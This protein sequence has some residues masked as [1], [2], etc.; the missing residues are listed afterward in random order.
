MSL[1]CPYALIRAAQSEAESLEQS[2]RYE[3]L[4]GRLSKKFPP[5]ERGEK[6]EGTGVGGR[7]FD[8]VEE[9]WDGEGRGAAAEGDGS[10]T[11]AWVA[12]EADLLASGLCYSGPH[13]A[14]IW[15]RT[16]VIAGERILDACS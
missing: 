16:W 6:A 15:V 14:E 4:E 8:E 3:N 10:A 5:R 9:G 11:H 1:N 12:G 13:W 2:D 7:G